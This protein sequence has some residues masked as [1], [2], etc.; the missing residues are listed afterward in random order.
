MNMMQTTKRMARN[1]STGC[2]GLMFPPNGV[3]ECSVHYGSGAPSSP[4]LQRAAAL[5]VHSGA[6]AKHRPSVLEMSHK[7]GF[8]TI[9]NQ[10]DD[11][12]DASLP[13][14]P[15]LHSPD[16]DV[17]AGDAALD[18]ETRSLV[19][20][21][22]TEFTGLST[23]PWLETKAQSTMKRVVRNVLEK[24]RYKYNGMLKT[25]CLDQ[26]GDNMDFV[27]SVAKSLFSD[28]TTNWGRIASL[29]AF[30]AVVSQYLKNKDRGHCVPLVAQEISSFLLEHQRNWLVK[31]NS[32][33]GFVEFFQEADP[34]S[35]VRKTLMA[36]AGF[37]GIGA[38]LALLIR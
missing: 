25:L 20:G 5:D 38:T 13:C 30:G 28:G 34:E 2:M 17:H 12:D 3:L 36:V 15:E 32:W 23:G 21:F 10:H 22:L 6:A 11:I 4:H 16:D 18:A 19:S 14:T 31:N 29:V 33:N 37:A 9:K 8:D 35:A 1:V 24:H 26:K 7:G 27:G